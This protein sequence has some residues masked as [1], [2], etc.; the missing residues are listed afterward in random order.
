[1]MQRVR[2]QERIIM[3]L[4]VEQGGM[5]KRD[6]ER[7]QVMKTVMR[8]DAKLTQARATQVQ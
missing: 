5:S 2:V 8:V 1:M 7:L 4:S 3:K 6:F